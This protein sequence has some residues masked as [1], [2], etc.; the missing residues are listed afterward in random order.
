MKDY[1]GYP[2]VDQKDS[3][4]KLPQISITTSWEDNYV[5]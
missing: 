2:E 4:T 3:K 1:R 5:S